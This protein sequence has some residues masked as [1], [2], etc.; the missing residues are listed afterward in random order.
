MNFNSSFLICQLDLGKQ[1]V[2]PKQRKG[3]FVQ[4]YKVFTE[5][6][7]EFKAIVCLGFSKNI[8]SFILQTPQCL[9]KQVP[10]YLK[11]QKVQSSLAAL[12]PEILRDTYSKETASPTP[13]Q[14]Y[15]SLTQHHPQH[16]LQVRSHLFQ[17]PC[18]DI[19][20]AFPHITEV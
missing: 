12:Y 8:L 15:G 11:V 3:G 16:S 6:Q 7:P 10:T 1:A 18:F 2:L 19:E 4:L 9:T 5:I 17:H 20:G 14:K 13:R